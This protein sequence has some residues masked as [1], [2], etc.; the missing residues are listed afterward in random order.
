MRRR[1]VDAMGDFA[2]ALE[3]AKTFDNVLYWVLL[4]IR[5]AFDTLL[6]EII[7]QRLRYFGVNE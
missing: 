3:E 1:T 7:L 5:R 6:E 2:T 4:D